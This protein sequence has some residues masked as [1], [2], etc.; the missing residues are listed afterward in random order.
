[1]QEFKK[2]IDERL[3]K[4]DEIIEKIRIR[5]QE[6]KETRKLLE[7]RVSMTECMDYLSNLGVKT[8]KFQGKN[9][10]FE[11]LKKPNSIIRFRP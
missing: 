5:D 1:V 9:L 3:K 11:K 8:V 10:K 2:V 4:R 7:S 6:F